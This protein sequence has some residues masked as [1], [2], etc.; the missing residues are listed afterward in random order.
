MIEAFPSFGK[1]VDETKDNVN[2]SIKNIGKPRNENKE[3][4]EPPENS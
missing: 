4:P 3:T 2:L 1:K